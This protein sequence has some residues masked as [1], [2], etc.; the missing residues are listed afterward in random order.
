MANESMNAAGLLQA[1]AQLVDRAL[2]QLDMSAEVCGEC[3]R[4]RFVNI[5]YARVF[6]GLE[7]VPERL[8]QGALRLSK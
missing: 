7:H 6:D 3:Q 5:D 1:A 4:R 8:R 2:A